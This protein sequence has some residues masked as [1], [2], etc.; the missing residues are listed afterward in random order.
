M[1]TALAA[2]AWRVS[3]FVH[4]REVALKDFSKLTKPQAEL[5]LARLAAYETHLKI[6]KVERELQFS[7]SGNWSAHALTLHSI[8]DHSVEQAIDS[9]N[10][11]RRG[12][13][14]CDIT[15]QINSPGG[16]F[17]AGFALY[18]VLKEAIAEGHHVRTVA[19]GYAASM[20][21]ILLQAGVTRQMAPN[22]YLMIHEVSSG[23]IGKM[24]EIADE[25]DLSKR[26]NNQALDILAAR[27]TLTVAQ[28]KNKT[29]RKDWWL[30]A[31]EALKFGF[32][33][34]IAYPG[35]VTVEVQ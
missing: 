25:A 30:S 34:S 14:E 23:V 29:M 5:E 9:V 12:E 27:S 21:G 10:H 31:D 13:P 20:G 19:Y 8:T 1:A 32:I 26:L 33:D 11:W 3:T 2:R 7:A 22:A 4:C 35:E 16:Y 6:L 15:I 28:L 24:S 18:D 17:F